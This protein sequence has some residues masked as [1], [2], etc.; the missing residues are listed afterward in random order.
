MTIYAAEYYTFFLVIQGAA[1]LGLLTGAIGVFA[2]LRQQSLLGDALSHAAFPGIVI[3]FLLTYSKNSWLL[4]IGGACIGLLGIVFMNYVVR[5]TSLK[6]DAI[7]GIVLSVFFGFGLVL[8]TIAQKVAGDKQI[9]LNKFLFGNV[10]TLLPSDII[11]IAC[12]TI[13]SIIAL[14]LCWKECIISMVDPIFSRTIGISHIYVECIIICLLL[15]AILIGL[16]TIGIVL[17]STMLIAPAAAARQWVTRMPTMICL[18]GFFGS[19]SAVTGVIISAHVDHLPTGPTIVVVASGI[20]L[21]S[22]L[23]GK[24]RTF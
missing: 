3:M 12:I 24:R 14:T 23:C 20:V 2:L 13:I 1:L 21:I 7:L 6:K 17:M 18:A 16:Q 4:L 15:T 11:T 10:A 22:L 9:I 5:Y 8:M 19:L